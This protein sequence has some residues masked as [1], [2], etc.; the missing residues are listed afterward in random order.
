MI[1]ILRFQIYNDK[2]VTEEK[3]VN[4]VLIIIAVLI[5]VVVF[6]LAKIFNFDMREIMELL[7]DFWGYILTGGILIIVFMFVISFQPIAGNSMVPNLEEGEVIVF[8]KFAYKFEKP[9]RNEIVNVKVNKKSYVK[10][11][12]G[13][14]GEKIEYMK[15]KIYIDDV[16]F[17]EPFLGEGIV[18][19][20][21]LF[22]D[23][24]TK[25][26]CPDG[27]IPEGMY[28]VLGDNRPESDDSRNPLFGL[29][30]LKNVKGK[31]LFRIWP[32]NKFGG[33]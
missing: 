15:G 16:P 24:C 27:V 13:L 28:L 12:I 31:L 5:L 21:F 7:R 10:R 33:I 32:V 22:E 25:E 26:D 1:V 14:P 18:T 3:G 9:K 6:I 4:M 20:N 29:V 17:K 30:P 11:V 8:S 23:I 2:I 19:S